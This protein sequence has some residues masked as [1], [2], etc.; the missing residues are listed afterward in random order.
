MKIKPMRSVFAN[1]AL[2]CF[3]A[4]IYSHLAC[5]ADS[6]EEQIG[7]SAAAQIIGAAPLHPSSEVQRYVNLLGNSLSRSSGVKYR[8]RFAVVN[9][10]AVNAFAAPGGY[11][12]VSSGLLKLLDT[13]HELA[14][15]LS[16]EIVHVTRK[17]HYS[18]IRRQQMASE[19]MQEMQKGEH[20]EDVFKVTQMSTQIYARGLDRKSE[21]EADRLG[22]EIM[23]KAGYDPAASVDVL[24][25]LIALQGNDPRAALLFSTHP[26]PGERLDELL[27]AGVEQLPRPPEA[28]P[29]M[30]KRF[31]EFRSNL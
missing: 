15:V 8:W 31:I 20:D 28:K 3:L 5:A 4:I 29:A 2:G 30:R 12:L 13:E 24:S 7:R 9:S 11:V 26:S 14:Y 21:F 25:K 22:I 23:T 27:A 16:H 19:V 1:V 18:L 10:D 17:H 6:Y